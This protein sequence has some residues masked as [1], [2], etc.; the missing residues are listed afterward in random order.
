MSSILGLLEGVAK[1]LIIPSST[2]GPSILKRALSENGR[3]VIEFEKAAR[4]FSLEEVIQVVLDDIREERIKVRP[5]YEN[6]S[7]HEDLKSHLA[8]IDSRAVKMTAL[9][10]AFLN[11]LG[12]W[13]AVR[14]RPKYKVGRSNITLW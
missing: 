1:T 3:S 13:S 6:T 8:A 4:H 7:Q 14:Q 5:E 9:Q 2:S 12:W 10:K 11:G